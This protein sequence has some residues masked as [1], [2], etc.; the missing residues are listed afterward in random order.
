MVW[1][2]NGYKVNKESLED[3]IN[4]ERVQY[5]LALS[6]AQNAAA[7]IVGANI[8]ESASYKQKTADI[9]AAIFLISAS[10]KPLSNSAR[11]KFL[12]PQ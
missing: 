11:S 3:L 1:T 10:V 4:S 8:D 6:D 9:L 2:S 7:A 5:E 12:I